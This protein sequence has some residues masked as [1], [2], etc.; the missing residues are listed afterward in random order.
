MA[1]RKVFGRRRAQFDDQTYIIELREDGLVVRR[2]RYAD[3]CKISFPRLLQY[4]KPQL[5]LNL[6]YDRLDQD[7]KGQPM[8]RV[9]EGFV[10]H[11]QQQGGDSDLHAGDQPAHE[12]DDGRGGGVD[13]P[14]GPERQTQ[15]FIG[16]ESPRP[17]DDQLS[18]VD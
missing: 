6:F 16:P 4:A 12:N 18:T 10:V 3:E 13:S 2:L 11:H 7:D 5:E 9:P 1:K 15:D 14:A 17:T 8:P